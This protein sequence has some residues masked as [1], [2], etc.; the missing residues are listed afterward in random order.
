MN[1]NPSLKLTEHLLTL[2]RGRDELLLADYMDL[3]PLYIKKGRKYVDNFLRA[4]SE[5]GSY[6]K[7]AEV[8]PHEKN[9]LDML[10]DHGILVPRVPPEGDKPAER[11]S[12]GLAFGNRRS[13]SLYLLI[14]QSCNLGCVYCLNGARTYR[15]DKGLKMGRE[16]AFRSV[17][18]CL[19]DIGPKG[20]L[21]IIF[22]GG[23]PLLNWPLA[24]EIIAYCEN[25]LKPKHPG[26]EIKYHLTTN[27][28]FI[29]DDLTRWARDYQI[30]FLCDVDGPEPIHD[31]CRPFRDGRP[32][33]KTVA[34]NVGNLAAAGLNVDLRATITAFNQDHL[35]EIAAHHKAIGGKSSA[36]VPVNPINSDEALLDGRLLP[37]PRKIMKGLTEIYRNKLWRE[38]ELYPFNEYAPR[39]RPGAGTVLG[40]GAPCGNTVIVDVQ[41]DVYPCIYLVGIRRFYLGN[42]MNE[43][44]PRRNLLRRMSAS[45]HVDHRAD[46]RTCAWRYA[47]GGGCALRSLMSV[48]NS[49]ACERVTA[50]WKDIACEGTKKIME[51][52]L[53][54]RA[55]RAVSN[56]L[57]DQAMRETVE[58][59][60][61]IHC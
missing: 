3:R 20:R 38:R 39:L 14:S 54:D 48:P 15:T 11:L 33:H 40:C 7:I 16:V 41:G 25:G 9:L 5:L 1:V 35:A 17:E 44:Y 23:E 57:E 46:C 34:R 61:T 22:F 10:L 6:E 43:S 29:P 50:Y 2:K 55:E 58:T 59:T 21:E 8:F 53:W 18:R 49:T 28:S 36:F 37:S 13:M 32:S 26:K 30:T 52:M 4:A 42:I 12:E 27:L 47:C 31:R 56:L 60:N 51:L 45:L 19:D 24:K